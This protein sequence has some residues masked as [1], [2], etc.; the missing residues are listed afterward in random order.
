MS[1]TS[2]KRIAI[3]HGR[4]YEDFELGQTFEHHWGR[5]ILEYDSVLFNSITC[6]YNPLYF[7]K[8]YAR[9]L[10]YEDILVN[11]VLLL[12]TTLGLSVEDLSEGGGPFLGV[13]EAK[14]TTP[15]Y[16]GVTIYSRT[17]TLDK[18]PTES[19]PGWGVVEWI[20]EGFDSEGKTLIKY[21]RRNLSK[22]RNPPEKPPEQPAEK[23]PRSK[24]RKRKRK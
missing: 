18:R 1:E 19:R 22:F 8:E 23:R 20:T 21:R 4:A 3:Q 12:Y 24:P 5:T 13:H 7:N 11:P 9:S 15:V 10:G 16:P 2:K 17:T 6:H 14:I